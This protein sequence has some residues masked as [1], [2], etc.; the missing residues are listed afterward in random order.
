MRRRPSASLWAYIDV[1]DLADALRLAAE[2]DLDT[3][4]V[5]YIAS[6]DNLANRP[7]AELV[8]H[9]HGDDDRAARALA[10]PDAP[11]PQHREGPSGCSA[12][13]RSA[14]GATT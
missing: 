2:S 9:H 6:P 1:Y 10:R 11:G 5:F 14:R 13:T 8:R 12:T 7:L 3:H 4:E